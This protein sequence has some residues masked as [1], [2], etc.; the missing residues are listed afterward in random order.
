MSTKATK[1]LQT[2]VSQ[3]DTAQTDVARNAHELL[4]LS[5]TSL[6]T[7]VSML[8]VRGPQLKLQGDF[9]NR[10]VLARDF[11][12]TDP[13]RALALALEVLNEAVENTSLE[14]MAAASFVAGRAQHRL[15]QH[16][17]AIASL[18]ESSQLFA[19]L[20]DWSAELEVLL[21][22]NR[23]YRNAGDMVLAGEC[24][25]RLLD[26]SRT[27]GRREAEAE[28]LN[29][30]ASVA[31]TIGH[32]EQASGLL[33]QSLELWRELG[34]LK[35]EVACLS[36]LGVLRSH[37][38]DYSGAIEAFEHVYVLVQE[39]H[40]EAELEANCLINIG[41]VFQDQ[42]Q[43]ASALHEYRRAVD[44]AQAANLPQAELIALTNLAETHLLAGSPNEAHGMYLELILRAQQLGL[45]S[46]EIDALEG[47]ARVNIERNRPEEALEAVGRALTMTRASG[48]HR[49]EVL[50][51]L[52]LAR[53]NVLLGNHTAAIEANREAI[54][55]ARSANAKKLVHTAEGNLSTLLESVSDL[56]QAFAHY[57]IAH[58]LEQE[59]LN[60]DSE[61]R[62]Q[63]LKTRFDLERAQNEAAAYRERTLET[64]R[65]NG[66]LEQ[67]V[68]E[69]TR[70]L[71]A[72][73]I[74][75]VTRLA[76]AAEYR[77]DNTGQHTKRVGDLSALL[78][79]ALGL[80]QTQVDTLRVASR[81]HD[82]GKIGVPDQILL[83][84][85]RL[86]PKEFEQIKDHTNIGAMMLS[87]GHSPILK[88]AE[89]IALTHHERWDGKG[90][91]NGLAGETIPLSGRIVAV[92]DVYDALISERPY[93]RAWSQQEA[94]IELEAQSGKMFD[95]QVIEAVRLVFAQSQVL[96]TVSETPTGTGL[97]TIA[98]APVLPDTKQADRTQA[99]RT[100]ADH[101][102]ENHLQ[103]NLSA[104][105]GQVLEQAWNIR[106][107]DLQHAM[108][109][110]HE[111]LIKAQATADRHSIGLAYRNI[112]FG[113]FASAE[114]EQAIEA[115][116]E[117]LEIG[118]ELED[119]DLKRDCSNYLGA[120]YS[121][122]GDYAT[123]IEYVQAT[124]NLS[125]L[126]ADHPGIASALTNLG[127]LCHY[128]GRNE[129]A[130]TLQ[131]ESLEISRALNDQRREAA[132][133]NNLGI[134]LTKLQRYDEAVQTLH[135]LR[136][137]A[138]NL[139][140]TYFEGSVLA[141]L[142]EVYIQLLQHQDA[143][144]ASQESLALLQKTGNPEGETQGLIAVGLAHYHLGALSKASQ[145]LERGL[146]LA[147][148]IGSKA[149]VHQLHRHLARVHQAEGQ[150][151]QAL[152]HFEHY[153]SLEQEISFEEAERKARASTA[154]REAERARAESEIFRLR[155][156][157]LSK[158]NTLF[159]ETDRQKSELLSELHEKTKQLNRLLN[160]DALTG[161][162]NRRHLETT[163]AE[164]LLK[165]RQA[166]R[167]L[168]V[169]MIDVDHFKQV[170]DKYSHMTGDQVLIRV[171]SILQNASRGRDTLAR[172]G[173]EEFVIAMPDTNEAQALVCCERLRRAV[174][175]HDWSEFHADLRVTISIGLAEDAKAENHEKLLHL[176]DD[177]LYE[178]KRR[179]RNRVCWS[180]AN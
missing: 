113:H 47:M 83:K 172:Y 48:D 38:G 149:M 141:N 54:Q 108:L 132:A 32:M 46:S 36:N 121:S 180:T 144:E 19:A 177:L 86:S 29:G 178:A 57:K 78:A 41:N 63:E 18:S 164:E 66:T 26:L 10:L 130:V 65:L 21:E 118:Q 152:T 175:T 88:I 120:V 56:E 6:E 73:Q 170:N 103:V 138:R 111:A 67:K 20:E 81:L 157:E 92:A 106:S 74:E 87:G 34:D 70:E 169:V 127:L 64:Q 142:S 101:A 50:L 97:L 96:N 44:I 125:R 4:A 22:L 168:C 15:A 16:K 99:D 153:H 5:Q 104:E 139:N 12:E 93:K 52:D 156:I 71:E 91:P 37:A 62:L 102:L 128:I 8:E 9:Q 154:Q 131:Q 85:D 11:L 122:L 84:P 49:R 114:Y 107:T 1:H 25:N 148:S 115:L 155:N 24:L 90:Y 117:G 55:L 150:Y 161:I 43:H 129:Q 69:R 176:A 82:V 59:L 171:A 94:L 77:D 162:Y 165:G 110:S 140:D 95:P 158:A 126:A 133:L 39:H 98:V 119:H 40:L 135:A 116:N 17:Q 3:G 145:F 109:L 167:P 143:L 45:H 159:V 147:E 68:H 89:Q 75:T 123:A 137:V 146:Q 163:L 179:G 112:G 30:L 7:V 61:R 174:E 124:L 14:D 2:Q 134:A 33:A 173:G 100:Q 51:L 76:L 13:E 166:K 72:A 79:E 105:L 31:F 60:E 151:Q 160:E 28:A 27:T 53:T 35:G 42:G 80:P 58:R 23:I 136:T